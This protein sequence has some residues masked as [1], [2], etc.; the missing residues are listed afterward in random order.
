M[1]FCVVST[2]V[3][4][5]AEKAI[6]EADTNVKTATKVQTGLRK[7]DEQVEKQDIRLSHASRKARISAILNQ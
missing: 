5:P 7:R 6:G 2:V 3:F 4:S 1:N